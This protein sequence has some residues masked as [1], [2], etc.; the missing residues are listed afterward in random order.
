MICYFGSLPAFHR[1]SLDDD[2]TV[3][4]LSMTVL[5]YYTWFAYSS[6]RE[7]YDFLQ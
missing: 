2:L 1:K 6:A 5:R 7:V 4:T 3:L